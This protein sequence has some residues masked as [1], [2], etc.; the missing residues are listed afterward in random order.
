M[1]KKIDPKKIV[2]LIQKELGEENKLRYI[3]FV[4]DDKKEGL[5]FSQHLNA[6]NPEAIIGILERSKAMLISAINKGSHIE[7]KKGKKGS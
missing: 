6:S 5:K 7:I 3:L 2:E 4:N 1:T